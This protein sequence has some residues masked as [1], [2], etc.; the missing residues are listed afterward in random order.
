MVLMVDHKLYF[1]FTKQIIVSVLVTHIVLLF[2]YSM[3]TNIQKKYRSAR[4]LHVKDMLQH[5]T[6]HEKNNPFN[7]T[8]YIGILIQT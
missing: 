4:A 2:C 1:L 3:S 8:F 7:P 6:L 5:D